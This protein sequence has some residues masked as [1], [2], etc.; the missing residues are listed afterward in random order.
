MSALSHSHC[1]QLVGCLIP[2]L[3]TY[4][5]RKHCEKEPQLFSHCGSFDHHAM[6]SLNICIFVF[7]DL[8]IDTLGVVGFVIYR[9]KGLGNSFPTVY[10]IPQ[11]I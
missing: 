7:L 6:Q 9:W 2:R 4:T 5:S 1:I 11:N 3:Y 10:H 8:P